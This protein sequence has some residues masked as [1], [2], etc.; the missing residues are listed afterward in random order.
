M[1]KNNKTKKGITADKKNKLEN[2][3]NKDNKETIF[4]YDLEVK[5]PDSISERKKN[6]RKTRNKLK[7]LEEK[8]IARNEKIKDKKRKEL[9]KRQ[10]ELKKQEIIEEKTKEKELKRRQKSL[11]PKLTEA[12]I[13]R[14]KKIKLMIKILFLL[15]IFITGI[16][17]LILSPIFNIK[18]ID[19]E[20]NSKVTT[21]E[22][23]S[24]SGLE[25][26]DNLY[27][28]PNNVLKKNIKQNAY[29]DN[30]KIKK[31][32]PS[33]IKLII[34]ERTAEYM[35]EIGSSYA[36]VDKQGYIL[37]ISSTSLEGKI[38]IL[39]YETN[40]EDI[41]PENKL[42]DNDLDKLDTIKQIM[43]SAKNASIDN[44]ITSINISNDDNY[45]I[46]MESEKKTS[47]IGD[48][49]NLDTKMLYIKKILSK[50]KDNEGEIYVNMDFRTKNPY[51]KEKV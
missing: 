7:E 47:Y 26:G 18:S 29:I 9:K 40:I 12:Q 38:K 32:L 21:N 36:Y 50:E 42:C 45:S 34:T 24:L 15:A 25:V 2:T 20:N 51:F 5:E 11:K 14:N 8:K 6:A 30:V 49:S 28:I 10:K 31:N 3:K 35:L 17:L 16:I 37:E 22:I 13:K 27:K 19:V 4:N 41:V 43:T 1:Q 23:V 48:N 39:G 33:E 46:Y 44:L